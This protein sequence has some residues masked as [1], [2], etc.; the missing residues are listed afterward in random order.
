MLHLC[1]LRI[2]RFRIYIH[3]CGSYA[4]LS[5]WSRIC[6][7]CVSLELSGIKYIFI[8]INCF[9]KAGFNINGHVFIKS[10]NLR[11]INVQTQFYYEANQ[12]SFNILSRIFFRVYGDMLFK[13][14][15][16]DISHKQLRLLN[17]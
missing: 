6:Y 17:A 15:M 8:F 10:I 9:R 13:S 5:F 14:L 7:T 16:K 4:Y 3:L 2:I 12:N 1:F 11:P